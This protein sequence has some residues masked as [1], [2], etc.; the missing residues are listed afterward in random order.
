MRPLD[1]NYDRYLND[2]EFR[3]CVDFLMHMI[4]ELQLSP[5]EVRQAAVYA[6]VKLDMLGMAHW[7]S[8]LQIDPYEARELEMKLEALKI[9]GMP[10]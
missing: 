2:K 5:Y 6:C 9:A 3:A 4:Q 1:S 7:S 8:G 10:K